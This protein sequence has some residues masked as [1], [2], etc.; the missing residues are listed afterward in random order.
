MLRN[1]VTYLFEYGSVQTTITR[2]KEVR[3]LAEKQITNAR[4]ATPETI[5]TAKRKAFAFITKEDVVKVLFDEIAPL[6]RDYNNGGYTRIVRIGPR[7]GDAAEMVVLELI[8]RTQKEETKAAKESGR[9][10]FGRRRRTAETEVAPAKSAAPTKPAAPTE[11]E[12]ELVVEVPIEVPE[13]VVV[14]VPVEEPAT[15]E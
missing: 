6:Y 8:G 5:L 2:A 12:E 15:V 13:E 3:S 10:R 11:P 7:R 9:R 4:N 1:L 14:E